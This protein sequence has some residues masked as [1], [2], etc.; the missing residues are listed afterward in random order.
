VQK[1]ALGQFLGVLGRMPAASSE[2]EKR[3]PIEPAQFGQSGLPT[4]RRPH[5]DCPARGVKARRPLRRRT[6]VAFH[7]EFRV[8]PT[9]AVKR[10]LGTKFLK[11]CDLAAFVTGRR[12]WLS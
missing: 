5:D 8:S 11:L 6:M 2:Y 3:I 1:K 4:L 12:P 10:C 9:I 7:K